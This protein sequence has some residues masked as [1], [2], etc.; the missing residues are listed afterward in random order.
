LTWVRPEQ[1]PDVYRD[2]FDREGLTLYAAYT[3]TP[4]GTR[5]GA[6]YVAVLVD[7]SGSGVA[8]H[9]REGRVVWLEDDCDD[10]ARMVAPE[11]VANFIQQPPAPE[12]D[13]TVTPG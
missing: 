11:R 7:S 1:V 8:M 10:L 9:T 4:I 5:Y 3:P 6:E 2:A 12:P 13:P